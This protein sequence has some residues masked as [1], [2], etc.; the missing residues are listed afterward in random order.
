MTDVERDQ[1]LMIGY[2]V[3]GCSMRHHLSEADTLS[4]FQKHRLTD[5]IRKKYN[6]LHTQDLDESILFAEDVLL[7]NISYEK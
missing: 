6:A 1:N 2:A 3:E 5:L 4:L 7:K